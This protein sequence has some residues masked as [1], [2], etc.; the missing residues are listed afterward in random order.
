MQIFF[1]LNKNFVENLKVQKIIC[2]EI[3]F[4]K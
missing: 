2:V 3:N 4:S 1:T